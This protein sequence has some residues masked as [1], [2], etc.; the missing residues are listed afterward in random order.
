MIIKKHEIHWILV[1]KTTPS[2]IFL[3]FSSI[4]LSHNGIQ[5]S[6]LLKVEQKMGGI[7]ETPQQREIKSTLKKL[8]E[9]N[10]EMMKSVQAQLAEQTQLL[11]TLMDLL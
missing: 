3:L 10:H 4:S 8:L 9:G 2:N 1:F 5:Q 11:Q 7:N 6:S